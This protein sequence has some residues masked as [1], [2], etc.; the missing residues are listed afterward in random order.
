MPSVFLAFMWL[1]I[2]ASFMNIVAAQLPE[3]FTEEILTDLIKQPLSLRF[4]SNGRVLVGSKRG[5]IFLIDPSQR[6]VAPFPYM[7][8][9]DVDPNGE[10][11]L[12]N[13]VLDANFA[14]NNYFY[15]YFSNI[16]TNKFQ[17]SRF[18]HQENSGG[19]KSI[20]AAESQKVIWVDPEPIH[21]CCHYGGGMDIG[22]AFFHIIISLNFTFD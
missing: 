14:S 11:G 5:N 7:T 19:L 6:P 21:E 4:I 12:L 2:G 15:A 16:K 13:F 9:P 10:R 22:N 1:S 8:V 17:I 3:G 20:G 18:T